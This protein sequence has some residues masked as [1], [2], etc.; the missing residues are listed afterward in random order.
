MYIYI[1]LGLV[2]FEGPFPEVQFVNSEKIAHQCS[3]GG[4]IL[5]GIV[6][7]LLSPSL[8][9]IYAIFFSI[10]RAWNMLEISLIIGERTNI[11]QPVLYHGL[12]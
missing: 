7:S 4:G 6:R 3:T 2:G 11:P 12:N 8:A 1:S 5:E 9:A 10:L